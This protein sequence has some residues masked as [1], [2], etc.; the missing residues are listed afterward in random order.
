MNSL[1]V[2]DAEFDEHIEHE[3]LGTIPVGTISTEYYWRDRWYNVFRFAGPD[4]KL[5]KFYCNINMPPHFDGETLSYIDLDID[6]LVEPDWSFSI[7]DIDDF[8]SNAKLY[9]YPIEIQQR[10]RQAVVELMALIEKRAF[11]FNE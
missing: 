4:R 1:L 7:L 5:K 10:A 8:E 6:V 9:N 2:L 11:P 3:S